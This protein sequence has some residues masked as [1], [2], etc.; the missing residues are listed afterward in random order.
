FERDARKSRGALPRHIVEMRR[1]A[2]DHC[3]QREQRIVA[4]RQCQFAHDDWNI[5]CPGNTYDLDL[6]V[7]S[8][9]PFQGVQRAADERLDDEI[10]ET[11]RDEGET[12]I[13]GQQLPFD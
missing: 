9:M 3:T 13:A 1:L 12:Q 6:L 7:G 5:E 4:A 8:A 10:V 11:R 2:A